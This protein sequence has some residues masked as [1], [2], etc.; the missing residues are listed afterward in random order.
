M[1]QCEVEGMLAEDR[2]HLILK[3]LEELRLQGLRLQGL[4][5]KGREAPLVGSVGAQENG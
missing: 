4:Y 2:S 5:S 3:S 1:K